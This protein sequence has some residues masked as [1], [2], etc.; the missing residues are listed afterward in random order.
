MVPPK[1]QTPF[2]EAVEHLRLS[3]VLNASMITA[4][5]R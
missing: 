2:D 5:E 3:E 4:K 1:G